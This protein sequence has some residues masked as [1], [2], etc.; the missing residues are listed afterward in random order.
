[1]KKLKNVFIK[2]KC[3]T[4]DGWNIQTIL[5]STQKES[6]ESQ[7]QKLKLKGLIKTSHSFP[8]VSQPV[9]LSKN[10]KHT[11]PITCQ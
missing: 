7:L 3:F 10:L 2:R 5:Y 1:M 8:L 4:E 6:W 9:L 11:I